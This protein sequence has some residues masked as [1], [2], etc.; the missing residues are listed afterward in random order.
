M[1][2]DDFLPSE[3]PAER[4]RREA[5]ALYDQDTRAYEAAFGLL[6]GDVDLSLHSLLLVAVPDLKCH[7]CG[8][9]NPTGRETGLD[10]CEA[11]RM[12]NVTGTVWDEAI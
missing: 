8:R 5:Q 6:R 10:Y 7:G 4:D 3:S 2:R 9:G 1:P 11:C 12:A